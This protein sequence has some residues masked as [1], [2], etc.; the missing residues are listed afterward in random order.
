MRH[1]EVDMEKFPPQLHF[2]TEIKPPLK[3]GGRTPKTQLSTYRS[4]KSIQRN[5]LKG[6]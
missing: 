5:S 4:S 6:R 3:A 2:G 1:G